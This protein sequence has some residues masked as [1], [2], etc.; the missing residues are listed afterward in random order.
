MKTVLIIG[1]VW[2]EP[3][4]SAAGSHMMQ[5][6]A[7]FQSQKYQITFCTAC[8]KTKNAVD[9]L[10]L[11]IT[12]VEIRLNHSSF[13]EFIKDLKPDIV[14]FDRF[15]TEEQFGWRVQEQC[16]KAMRIL[17]TEDLH[18]L[19]KGRRQAFEEASNFD[20]SFLFNEIA[21][22]ELASIFRCDFSLI[23]SEAELDILHNEFKVDS[24]LLHYFPFL[25]DALSEGHIK[26]LPKFE[27]RLDFVTIG[28]FLHAPNY[29]AVLYLKETI[30]P[31]IRHQLPEA[32]LH[33]YGAYMPQKAKALT[34]TSNGFIIEGF[35]NDV[36]EVM[37]KAKVCLAPLR[38][39]AGLKGKLIDAMINGTPSVTSTIGS[40]GLYGSLEPNG[41]ISDT[42]EEF[43]EKSID[44]YTNEIIWKDK[45]S[46]GF[47]V[48][49]KRFSKSFHHEELLK[50]L[51]SNMVH[52]N[53]HRLNNFTGIMLHHALLQ[54]TK[55][56]SKWIEEKNKN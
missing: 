9:F 8:I 43:V 20:K 7:V 18:C 13:D 25:I 15:M 54:S 19:R 30:W 14:I 10:A 53:N 17:N 36:Q 1:S 47:E 55:Y 31:L 45:Q 35:A 5:L 26:K 24:K 32:S 3:T 12:E 41:F 21:K 50:I 27:A 51:K 39:G 16:P 22:R 46:C 34:D 6:I 28:N 23:I 48:V 56:M 49:N 52:L 44:L 40:E 11:G 37:K 33:I 42:P 2:P 38:F 4:S 29:D